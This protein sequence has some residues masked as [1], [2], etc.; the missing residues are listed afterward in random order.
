MADRN[1]NANNNACCPNDKK[2]TEAV[3]VDVARVY[4]SCADKDCLA[5]L[6]VYFPEQDE[7]V[8]QNAV[9]VRCRGVE[10]CDV[11]VEVEKIPFN[12]G[13]YSVDL[14]FFFRVALD[15]IV[16]PTSPVATVYGC[17]VYTKKCILYG[18]EGTVKVFSS[19][20]EADGQDCQ[21]PA[22]NTN[23]VAT[24]QV[25]EPLCLDAKLC[26]PC[27]CCDNLADAC[28]GIPGRVRG[29]FGGDFKRPSAEKA[30]KVTI[31]L[32][33][34][35]QLT[36]D[37]QMLIPA[38]DFCV[39]T[40]ECCSDANDDPCDAFR[41]IRFPVNEFFPPDENDICAELDADM[42]KGGCGCG[43]GK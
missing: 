6:R 39:P 21:L 7:V 25:A 12:R 15:A 13:F 28:C 34:I 5:D 22:T 24:V 3:C 23:P 37:V 29:L 18:S 10:V 1:N 35:I 42:F 33:S 20:Y 16:C 26:R 40:K 41:K 4:D 30:V 17:C 11:L 36:R 2:I 19:E 9:S 14:T 27:D 8:V 43:C 32:F 31:G 38:Y